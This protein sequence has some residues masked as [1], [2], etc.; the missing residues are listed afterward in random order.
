MHLLEGREKLVVHDWCDD[1]GGRLCQHEINMRKSAH[2]H[3]H[4]GGQGECVKRA[5]VDVAA[6]LRRDRSGWTERRGQELGQHLEVVVVGRN[7]R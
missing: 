4:G 6:H 3:G 5:R 2:A 1:R 7:A